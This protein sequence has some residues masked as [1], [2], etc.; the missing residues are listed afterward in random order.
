MNRIFYGV[1][2]G[3]L[4]LVSAPTPT[5]AH[6]YIVRA[7]P[8]NRAVLERAPTR[9]QYW[10]SEALEPNF[11]EL[12][13]RDQNGDILASGGVSEDDN[14]LM[15]VR[16]PNNLPDGAYIVELRP[17][18]ASDGHVIAESRVFFVGEEVGGVA[19]QGASDTA[20]PLE[21]IWRAITYAGT[22][23]LFGVFMLYALVLVPAW[24]NLKH[25][26][27][28]LPPRVMTRLNWIAGIALLVAFIGNGLALIQQTM[29]FFGI[30]F[31]QALDQNFWSVVRI[32]SRFGDIWNIRMLFLLVVAAM[33]A[34]SLYFRRSQP[35]TVRPFWIANAW[36]MSLVLGSF[37]V[38]SHAA[39]SLILPWV[40]IAVD[41]LHA[42]AVGL[43][44]GGLVA[45]VLVLP[46]AL[47]PYTDETRRF[48][49]IAVL[50]RFSRWA[51]VC[52]ALVT[53]TG[54]YSASN[55]IITPRDASTNFGLS[56]FVKLALVM[57]LIAIG[58]LHHIALR[59][60]KYTRFSA[61]IARVNTFLPSLRFEAIFVF[62]VLGAVAW[63][64]A[65]PVPIPEFATQEVET[66][67]AVINNATINGEPATIS[68]TI[69]PGGTGVNTY[70]VQVDG[71]LPDTTDIQLTM[72]NPTRDW[73][74]DRYRLEAVEDGLYVT[75][76]DDIDTLG[77]WW[78]AMDITDDDGDTTRYAFSWDITSE[79]SVIQSR[80]PSLINL[81]ALLAVLIVSGWAMYPL[82]TRVYD[83]LDLS[84]VTV[85]IAIGIVII[86][87]FFIVFG[88]N[89]VQQS[90]DEFA[91]RFNPEP[92]IVNTVLP[93]QTSLELGEALYLEHCIVWQS[94]SR[95]FN[96]FRDRIDTLRDEE[97]YIATIDGWR[98]LPACEGE[99]TVTERWH[100]VNYVRT[101]ANS[102]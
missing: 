95:D 57:V 34:A 67:R 79:A 74:G 78:T 101:I 64:S 41:W 92:N 10:F 88:N 89:L 14:T 4:L 54:I 52:V 19:G 59:P 1:L 38:L 49:L 42:L 29:T 25:R 87:I 18:F 2:L 65:T 37:S 76:G 9:L 60:A 85:T 21:V 40:G 15:T 39:G 13:L 100:I 93:D 47:Q 28:L 46:V 48:A 5:N 22:L 16:L 84:P 61:L 75:A 66:P 72:I 45:L 81:L 62:I 73:R 71:N 44:A 11:S 32:G 17:A 82:A 27:G 50:R 20:V 83:R 51:L 24:G 80:N 90:R 70:D 94:V 98:N 56:L 97:L 23:V 26:A 30:G 12:N 96:I 31:T 55:W 77:A 91:A 33:F 69:S 6:G 7:I 68:M 43:W 36:M 8:E 35:E 102:R 58:G 53:V 86:T 63:L 99:I 3:I